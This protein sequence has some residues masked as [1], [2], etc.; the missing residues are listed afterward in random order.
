MKPWRG[1]R[2]ATAVILLSIADGC[3]SPPPQ[4]GE[5]QLRQSPV[6]REPADAGVA[7]DGAATRPTS[8]PPSDVTVEDLAAHAARHLGH[9][10]RV[11]GVLVQC[12]GAVCPPA[13]CMTTCC[14]ECASHLFLAP[15][16]SFEEADPAASCRGA[17]VPLLDARLRAWY[18]VPRDRC[19]HCVPFEIGRRVLIE[20]RLFSGGPTGTT[21]LQ[22]LVALEPPRQEWGATRRWP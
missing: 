19:G 20:G 7:V 2:C 6:G 16:E 1:R 22:P 12:V 10:V 9:I 21:W 8:T 18:C 14:D 15:R 17:K 5:R 3:G 4:P 11:D 13:S